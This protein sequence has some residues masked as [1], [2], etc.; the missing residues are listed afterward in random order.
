MSYKSGSYLNVNMLIG[1]C[2]TSIKDEILEEINKEINKE[3]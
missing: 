1:A 3:K 2:K